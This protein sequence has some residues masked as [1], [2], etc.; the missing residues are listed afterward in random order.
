M[1]LSV[2]YHVPDVAV[3]CLLCHWVVQSHS[4]LRLTVEV[5]CIYIIL[6]SVFFSLFQ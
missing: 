5:V 4:K 3:T 6:I 2:E 1:S